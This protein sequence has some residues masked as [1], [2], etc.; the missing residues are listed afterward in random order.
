ST[1]TGRL[2]ANL[3]EEKGWTY[4][5]RSGFS[6]GLQRGAWGVETAVDDEVSDAAVAEILGEL[7]RFCAE[8]VGEDEL[9]RAKDA[10]VLSL[11]RA[12]ESPARIVSR[13]ATLE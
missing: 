10:M 12:F 2:G 3:R 11:P 9:R 8:P 5:V 13:F 1:I 7:E 4:G 6:A